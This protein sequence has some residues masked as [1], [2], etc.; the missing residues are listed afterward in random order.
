MSQ[1][2]QLRDDLGWRVWGI[3]GNGI[4]ANTMTLDIDGHWAKTAKKQDQVG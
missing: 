3:L 2:I 1:A 4:L